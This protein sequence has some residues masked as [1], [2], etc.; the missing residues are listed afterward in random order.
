MVAVRV[1]VRRSESSSGGGL[2]AW[3]GAIA[4]PAEALR[5]IGEVA[6]ADAAER[7]EART[8]PWGAKW[9]PPSPATIEIK[10]GRTDGRGASLR[11][12]RFV[13]ILDGGRRV[14]VGFS[15]SF[16]RAFHGGAPANRI[17]G[18]APA[19]IPARP[20]LP[21]RG[22]RHALPPTLRDD[23]LAAFREGMRRAVRGLRRRRD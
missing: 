1:R 21:L 16:A 10:G 2:D 12:S 18:R 6:E 19:P 8:D 13:E 17:F 23:V 5:A 11:G 9:A 3:A 20:L 14:V 4:E 7:L 15:A 22:R